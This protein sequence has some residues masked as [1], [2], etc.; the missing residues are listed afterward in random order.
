MEPEDEEVEKCTKHR[1][2]DNF[3]PECA[4]YRL[5]KQDYQFQQRKRGDRVESASEVEED[6]QEEEED[7]RQCLKRKRVQKRETDEEFKE[8][9]KWKRMRTENAGASQAC[10]PEGQTDSCGTGLSFK[11]TDMP[12][13]LRML[14]D[15]VKM[16]K[17]K[18][19]C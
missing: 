10:E 3:C 15:C 8:Y 9:L 14:K 7:I 5:S 1:S 6:D 17:L 4:A 18:L 12:K 16:K 11:Q 19:I 13:E 2:H